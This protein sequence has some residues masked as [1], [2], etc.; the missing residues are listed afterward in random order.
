M[1]KD[2]TFLIVGSLI[3]AL[4]TIAALS[5]RR[6][7]QI[8][9]WL[10][11]AALVS[12]SLQLINRAEATDNLNGLS[13][14]DFLRIAMPAAL[15]LCGLLLTGGSFLA[16]TATTWTFAAFIMVAFTSAVYSVSPF[17]TI[18]KC[19]QVALQAL[20]VWA[21]LS[22]YESLPKFVRDLHWALIM[23]L[24]VTIVGPVLRP[25]A[26]WLRSQYSADARLQGGLIIIHPNTLGFIAGAAIVLAALLWSR[27]LLTGSIATLSVILG[28]SVLTM[29]R[30]RGP[31]VSVALL[32][33]I[34]LWHRSRALSLLAM[35]GLGAL[36]MS[37]FG[38][39]FLATTTAWIQRGQSIDQLSS[40]TGRVDVWRAAWPL[41]Q[42][43]PVFGR[44]FYAAHRSNP[45]LLGNSS[46]STL[47][48]MWAETALG[49]GLLG[50]SLLV[51]VFILSVRN[52]LDASRLPRN[53]RAPLMG[54]LLFTLAATFYNSSL[55][56]FG[57]NAAF[58]LLI[59]LACGRNWTQ[60]PATSRAPLDPQD[61]GGF[62]QRDRAI[63]SAGS[64]RVEVVAV[65]MSHRRARRSH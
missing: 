26:A 55:Q 54:L 51:L 3:L 18:G 31:L 11:W 62:E 28:A 64:R 25:D 44:G 6:R 49:V 32:T 15:L 8:G 17:L 20:V 33:S 43:S 12:P 19:L 42:E 48:N 56:G 9:S 46:L 1:T 34:A 14:D 10:L 35:G 63:P 57:L 53:Y 39:T 52:L 22:T 37:P 60:M 61:G 30:T 38:P 16:F 58:A 27:R 24:A 45:A 13:G 23:I 47:D 40:L 21:L 65:P 5:H 2:T 36:L 59:V 29:T 4:V 50:V 41:F 7:R